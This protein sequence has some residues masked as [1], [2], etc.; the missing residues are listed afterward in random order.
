M[1]TILLLPDCMV[2]PKMK[3]DYIRNLPF[4]PILLR[5]SHYYNSA[6]LKGPHL[7]F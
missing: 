3:N 5:P 1:N 6:Y 7:A 2:N 4:F